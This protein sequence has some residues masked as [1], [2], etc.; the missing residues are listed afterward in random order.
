MKLPRARVTPHTGQP[1]SHVPTQAWSGVLDDLVAAGG[2]RIDFCAAVFL[3]SQMSGN[4]QA[5]LDL[6]GLP[7]ATASATAASE[8]GTEPGAASAAGARARYTRAN[9][10]VSRTS[11]KQAAAAA[12]VA[13]TRPK[14]AAAKAA[15]P[16]AKAAADVAG[17][18]QW[19]KLKRQDRFA[20]AS[21]IPAAS[22]VV[23]ADWRRLDGSMET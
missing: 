20:H 10:T 8:R 12:A 4:V 11:Q 1:A 3:S 17:A 6:G 14:T 16:A 13:P 19:T 23:A 2:E 22:A 15:L 18:S 9:G 5:L 21:H 7:S